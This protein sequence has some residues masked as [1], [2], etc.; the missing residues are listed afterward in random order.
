MN[1]LFNTL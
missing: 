1:I